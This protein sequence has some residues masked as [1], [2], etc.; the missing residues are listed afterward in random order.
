[1]VQ[2]SFSMDRG[3]WSCRVGHDRVTECSSAVPAEASGKEPIC[4][5]RSHKRCGFDPQV[6][7]SPW[8]RAWKPTPV[9]LLGES[10]GQRSLVGY[11]PW[12]C[13][14]LDMTEAP[15]HACTQKSRKKIFVFMLDFFPFH[16]QILSFFELPQ[17]T[18]YSY[19]V[20]T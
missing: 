2:F 15:Q 11:S 4:Q 6:G 9:F 12:G 20:Q 3:A 17:S 18:N 10:H 1:M 16:D 7:K 5:H 19:S 14:E 8:K 13:R